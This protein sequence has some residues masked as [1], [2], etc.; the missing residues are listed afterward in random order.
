MEKNSAT[1]IWTLCKKNIYL[2]I[3]KGPVIIFGL[4]FPLFLT[5]S[6]VLGRDI[7][8]T[9][10]FI[11]IVS[12]TSFFTGTAISPVIFPIETREKSLE[13]ILTYPISINELLFSILLAS[14]LYSFIISLIIALIFSLFISISILSMLIV[15]I[16]LILMAILGS[17]L[18]LLVSANPSDMT[19]DIMLIMNLIKFPLLFISGIFIPLNILPIYG[20]FL[21]FLSP[22]TFLVDLLRYCVDGNNFFASQFDILMLLIWIMILFILVQYLHRKTMP[23][24][25][26]ETGKKMMMGKKA[27]G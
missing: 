13:R 12:M 26:S 15:I 7:T 23:M 5:I 17:L 19:S 3:R 10:I 6:W 25:L 21:S 18:G 27:I 22:L 2:Y 20:V 4:L 1:I 9:Q 11:G 14:S 24:R 16:G 8:Y